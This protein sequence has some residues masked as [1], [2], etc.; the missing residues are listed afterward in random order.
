[1]DKE[2][3]ADILFSGQAKAATADL[4]FVEWFGIRP[5][6]YDPGRAKKLMADAGYPNGF[7]VTLKTFKTTPGAELPTVGESVA[8]YWKE[9][10]INV[11]IVPADWYTVRAD[12]TSGNANDFMW[13]R[14]GMAMNVVSGLMAT[15]TDKSPFS[16]F[17]TP[18]TIAMFDKIQSKLDIDKRSKLIAGLGDYV[19]EEA[20][21]LF[22]VYTNEPYGASKKIGTWPTP[23]IRPQNFELIR[24]P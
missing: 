2:S 8:M 5:Y 19:R 24:R 21:Y 18:E 4:P 22:V 16:S 13:T 1:V 14:R 7:S 11:K 23:R 9:I 12:W 17:V 15:F 20:P 3:I 10:G 6:P